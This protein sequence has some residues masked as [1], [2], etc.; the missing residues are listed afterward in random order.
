MELVEPPAQRAARAEMPGVAVVVLLEILL[1]LVM[2][3]RVIQVV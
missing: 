1:V 3:R 2:L